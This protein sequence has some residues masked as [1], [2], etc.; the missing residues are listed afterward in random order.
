MIAL[1]CYKDAFKKAGIRKKD[2]K[3]DPQLLSNIINAI[4]NGD[5][6]NENNEG[7]ELMRQES[8]EQ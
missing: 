6:F 2:L 7:K 3:K 8:M 1:E 5:A 4:Q